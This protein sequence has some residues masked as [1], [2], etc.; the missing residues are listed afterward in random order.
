V[1]DSVLGRTQRRGTGRPVRR[2]PAGI[3]PDDTAVPLRTRRRR[4]GR[5][6]RVC[7]RSGS[8]PLRRAHGRR[9]GSSG[10]GGCAAGWGA[11][12][13]PCWRRRHVGARV[14]GYGAH[15][16]RWRA[17]SAGGAS[18]QRFIAGDDQTWAR[19]PRVMQSVL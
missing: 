2:L 17:F 5:R 15:R 10:G 9:D 13:G 18:L 19:A 1:R 11:A 14:L 8:Q 6:S 4:R 12:A 16:A 3:G 7:A